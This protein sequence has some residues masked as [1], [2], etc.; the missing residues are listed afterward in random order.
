MKHKVS[1][2]ERKTERQTGVATGMNYGV[3]SPLN[4]PKSICNPETCTTRITRPGRLLPLFKSEHL[5]GVWT[6]G[7]A[8]ISSKGKPLGTWLV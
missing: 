4:W 6:S 7:L 2:V 8:P 5:Q 1:A 3:A